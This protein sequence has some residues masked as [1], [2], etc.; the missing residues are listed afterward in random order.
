MEIY[1]NTKVPIHSQA[2]G[3]GLGETKIINYYLFPL[4]LVPRIVR[5]AV[6]CESA[7]ERHKKFFPTSPLNPD[8]GIRTPILLRI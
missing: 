2:L 8:L 6:I 1:K 4:I 3:K 7:S 5:I